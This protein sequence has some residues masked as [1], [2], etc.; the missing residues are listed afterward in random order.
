MFKFFLSILSANKY[1]KTLI[2][3]LFCLNRPK[4]LRR[5]T[6]AICAF[7]HSL[8]SSKFYLTE[9]FTVFEI[10]RD[11]LP[12]CNTNSPASTFQAFFVS[13]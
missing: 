13:S 10:L 7:F 1:L 8:Q 12:I 9:I 2:L 11:E 3:L 5:K 4:P 6:T